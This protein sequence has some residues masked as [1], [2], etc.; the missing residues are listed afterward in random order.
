MAKLELERVL[1]SERRELSDMKTQYEMKQQWEQ[2]NLVNGSSRE[3]FMVQK[4][5]LESLTKERNAL[6]ESVGQLQVGQR[7]QLSRPE[8][9]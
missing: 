5:Q 3:A 4:I 9:G 6:S 7:I 8:F 2:E 1:E